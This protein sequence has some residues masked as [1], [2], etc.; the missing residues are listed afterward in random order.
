LKLKAGSRVYV[1]DG[2]RFVAYEQGGD[3][4]F[5][6]LSFV[7]SETFRNLPSHDL[8]DDRPGRYPSPDGQRSAVSQTDQH[9]LAESRFTAELVSRIKSWCQLSAGNKFVL[10]ADPRSM[11]RIRRSLTPAIKERMLHSITGDFVHHPASEITR[12]VEDA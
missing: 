1:C 11:G 4:E 9:E 3:T 6:D 2:G 5:L 12:V 7:E 8:G 10:I